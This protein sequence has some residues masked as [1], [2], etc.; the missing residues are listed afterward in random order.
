VQLG[1]GQETAYTLLVYLSGGGAPSSAAAA[2][3]GGGGREALS[4]G[5][6]RAG[7]QAGRGRPQEHAQ[8][9][10][11]RLS[12]ELSR[13]PLVGVLGWAVLTSPCLVRCP[14]PLSPR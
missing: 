1:Q 8:L 6:G 4:A 3:S 12:E 9:H 5:T 2:S 10:A 13:L 7:R 14:M 11:Q